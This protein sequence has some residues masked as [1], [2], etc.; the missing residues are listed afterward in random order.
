MEIAV[1]YLSGDETAREQIEDYLKTL[2]DDKPEIVETVQKVIKVL[3]VPESIEAVDDEY[4]E[5]RVL[6]YEELVESNELSNKKIDELKE[7]INRLRNQQLNHNIQMEKMKVKPSESEKE[8]SKT[9]AKKSVSTDMVKRF[10]LINEYHGRYLKKKFFDSL[11]HYRPYR[12]IASSNVGELMKMKW[13][14]GEVVVCDTR[15]GIK[16]VNEG[17]CEELG[18]KDIQEHRFHIKLQYDGIW[19][20][21]EVSGVKGCRIMKKTD[22]S[23]CQALAKDGV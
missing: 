9:T 1:K 18:A 17:F 11:V 14:N 21:S 12:I 19:V 23:K 2:Q 22:Y 3:P 7:E 10:D 4:G 8:P 5:Q 15:T 16:M 20:V 6:S 13:K